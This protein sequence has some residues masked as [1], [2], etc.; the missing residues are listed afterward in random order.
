MTR[1]LRTLALALLI[2]LTCALFGTRAL[3]QPNISNAQVLATTV[4][5]ANGTFESGTVNTQFIFRATVDFGTTNAPRDL[6]SPGGT[7]GSPVGVVI[8]PPDP[9]NPER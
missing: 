2:V 1:I 4:T 6:Y 3:A 5:T 8:D 7:F 9:A